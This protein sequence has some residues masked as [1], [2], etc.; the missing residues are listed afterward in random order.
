MT[1]G[2]GSVIH[3]LGKGQIDLKMTFGNVLTLLDVQHVPDISKNLISGSLLIQYGYKILLE[4]NRLVISKRNL[5]VS[6]FV[7]G[8]LFRFNAC[9]PSNLSLNESSDC[10]F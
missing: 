8:D 4:S 5:F 10:S 2:N 9:E 1:H 3:V 7:S 6:C